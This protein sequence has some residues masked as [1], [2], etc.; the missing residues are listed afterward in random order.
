MENNSQNESQAPCT[1]T[2]KPKG[3]V[4][5]TGNFLVVDE[6]GKT[7]PKKERISICRCGMSKNLPFCDGA[8]KALA[9]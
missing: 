8:H 2:L 4:T 7:L 3:P 9:F 1:I 5:I 6:E